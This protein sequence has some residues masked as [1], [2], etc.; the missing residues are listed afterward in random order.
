MAADRYYRTG[1]P[2]QSRR[3]S[4]LKLGACQLS[5]RAGSI[6]PFSYVLVSVMMSRKFLKNSG[7]FLYGHPYLLYLFTHFINSW[8]SSVVENLKGRDV[9]QTVSSLLHTSTYLHIVHQSSFYIDKWFFIESRGIDLSYE[10]S[11]QE[12]PSRPCSFHRFWKV[13]DWSLSWPGT[14]TFQTKASYLSGVSNS[15]R[16]INVLSRNSQPQALH[17]CHPHHLV[18]M[19]AQSWSQYAGSSDPNMQLP[20]GYKTEAP[21]AR[22]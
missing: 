1:I 16:G 6:T 18:E 15:I 11:H 13:F 10:W 2:V 5:D 20:P 3:V 12:N 4:P 21:A 9:G 7:Y 17:L 22:I 8:R 14:Q 19:A